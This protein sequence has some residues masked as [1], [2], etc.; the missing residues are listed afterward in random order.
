MSAGRTA[1]SVHGVKVVRIREHKIPSA[2]SAPY[3]CV[4]GPDGNLW[5]CESGAAKIGR[6]DP[7]TYAFANLHCRRRSATPIGIVLGRDGNLWFAE[8]KANKIGRYH[9]GQ[10]HC[11]I[12]AADAECRPDGISSAL[13]AICGFPK[14]MWTDRPHHART[15]KS[16]SSRPASRQAASRCRSSCATARCGSARPRAT[17]SAASPSTAR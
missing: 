15:E 6:L 1:V 9:A 16:P 17:A 13:T 2:N 10:R 3:I 4:E 11:R 7:S 14:P 12:P 5:F 8:K